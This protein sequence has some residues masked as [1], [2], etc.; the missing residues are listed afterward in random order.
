VVASDVAALRDLVTDG[1]TGRL[2]A[3]GDRADLVRVL[4]ELVDDPAARS[5]LGAAARRWVT[6]ARSWDALAAE[7]E[8]VYRQLG[9]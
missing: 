9:V 4:T 2:F 7:V 5:R 3:K 8:I 6:A 1:A